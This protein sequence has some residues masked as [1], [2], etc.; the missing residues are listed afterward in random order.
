MVARTRYERPRYLPIVFAFAGDSTMTS[1]VA[2]SSPLPRSSDSASADFAFDTRAVAFVAR[3]VFAFV[4]LPVLAFAILVHRS[5][6]AASGR[7]FQASSFEKPTQIVERNPT[8]E[9]HQC[10][11]DDVLQLHVADRSR[12]AERQQMTPRF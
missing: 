8:V 6:V 3:F 7:I 10:A 1:D 2:P 5:V 12:P 4:V 9:L 11:L